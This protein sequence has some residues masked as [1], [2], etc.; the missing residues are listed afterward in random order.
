M[1][2]FSLI[3]LLTFAL[4]ASAAGQE[5]SKTKPS[6]AAHPTAEARCRKSDSIYVPL[7]SRQKFDIFL[8]RTY[9]PYTFASA[10]AN[11][12]WAQMWGQWYQY[13][14]G[15]QGWGKRFGATLADTEGRGF[16][17]TFALSSLLHQDPRYFPAK[18]RGI[19]PRSWYA[20]T[21]V[22]ITKN[23]GGE[24]TFNSS[25]ILGTLFAS[26]LE[27][28]YYPEHDRGFGETMG[29][30]IG[31]IGSDATSNLLR[32]FWPD[33]KRIFRKHE[34]QKIKTIEEKLPHPKKPVC[35]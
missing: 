35:K 33:I 16:I 7:S 8:K 27:N 5:R 31:S 15:M 10:A 17:Q 29:R 13:G 26:S 23:D 21:R 22:L 20:T 12:T 14:G 28:A 2:L 32:E 34:P 11:A 30:F 24:N 4:A 19:I 25:E 3:G 9:S 18:K 6:A 1:R